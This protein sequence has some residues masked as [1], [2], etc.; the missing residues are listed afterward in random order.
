MPASTSPVSTGLDHA[1]LVA[2]LR[3]LSAEGGDGNR[4]VWGRGD[5]FFVVSGESGGR[6][7]TVEAAPSKLLAEGR[8][9]SLNAVRG[10]RKRGF[11]N[12]PGHKALV[13]HV[14]LDEAP[15][16]PDLVTELSAAFD[17]VYGVSGEDRVSFRLGPRDTTQNPALIDAMREMA[18]KRDHSLR[19][20]LYRALLD[21]TLLVV[22]APE[23]EAPASGLLPRVVGKLASWDVAAAFSDVE[24]LRRW[25][26]RQP[27][28]RAVKGRALFPALVAHERLGSLL[29]N[30]GGTVGGELYRNELQTL[31]EACLRSVR[32]S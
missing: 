16:L 21:A 8:K 29:I 1:G 18:K 30:P 4:L 9:L 15:A 20:R 13:R 23:G 28:F 6:A 24:T 12:R 11:A 3:R 32:L 7:L 31:A 26:V 27:G 5:A 14:A 22:V 10:L 25:D 2:A 17:E 19:T